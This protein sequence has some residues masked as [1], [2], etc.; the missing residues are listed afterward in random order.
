[1]KVVLFCGGQGM[2]LRDYSETVP[3]PMVPI[4]DR[5]I[6][7]HLMKYYAYFGHTDF[8]LALGYRSEAIKE[9]FLNYKEWLTND[10]V[11]SGGGRQMQLLSSDIEDWNI[12]FADTGSQSTIGER[13]AAVEPYLEGEATFLANYAD[14]LTDLWLPDQLDSFER[15]GKVASFMVVHSPQSFHVARVAEDGLCTA[16]EPLGD[17]DIWLN[18]GFFAFRQEI[19]SYIRPGEELVVEPFQRLIDEQMLLAYRYEGFW[20]AMDTFKDRQAL[21]ERHKLGDAPW[22]VWKSGPRTPASA[23]GG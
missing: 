9:Y 23:S 11:L 10:F 13:L 3:K 12:T 21:E 18:A 4:G 19:F 2:R 20:Q 17:A 16:I 15:S 14:G 6:L 7:W 8:V 5:P 22:Q 1:V